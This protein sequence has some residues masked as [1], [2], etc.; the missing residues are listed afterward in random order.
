VPDNDSIDRD[1]PDVDPS[2]RQFMKRMSGVA[3]AAPVIASFSMAAL[4]ASPAY[5]APNTS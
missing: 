2:R 1:L 4:D 3:V 5:A